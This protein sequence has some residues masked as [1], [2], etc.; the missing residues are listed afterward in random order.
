MLK[1]PMVGVV[2]SRAPAETWDGIGK[3]GP[4]GINVL[5]VGTAVSHVILS[6]GTVN[7]AKSAIERAL[8]IVRT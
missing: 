3:F 1:T 2:S 8:F 6:S 4:T 5:F 7:T